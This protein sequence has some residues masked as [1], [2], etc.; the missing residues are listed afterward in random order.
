[1]LRPALHVQRPGAVD[2]LCVPIRCRSANA[3]VA[4][5]LDGLFDFEPIV[6]CKGDRHIEGIPDHVDGAS[7][8]LQRNERKAFVFRQIVVGLDEH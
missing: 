4:H 7:R 5:L 2:L 8:V 3:G 6:A 1:M